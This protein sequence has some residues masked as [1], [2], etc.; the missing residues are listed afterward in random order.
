MNFFSF[1][2]KII[3]FHITDLSDKR[4]NNYILKNIYNFF[5]KISCSYSDYISCPSKK[6]LKKIGYKKKSFF[7]PNSPLKIRKKINT[8]KKNNAIISLVNIDEGTDWDLIYKSLKLVVLNKPN[9][10]L[11]VTGNIKT[12]YS[13]KIL[14]KFNKSN[15]KKNISFVGYL[16]KN[17]LY[18]LYDKCK[19]GLTAYK[20]TKKHTYWHYGDSIKIR[21]YAE[22][23]LIILTEGLYY[24]SFEVK[25]LKLGKIYKNYK[26]LA[27][28]FAYFN[29]FSYTSKD[30]I[31]RSRNW[32]IKNRKEFFLKKFKYKINQD[33]L[34]KI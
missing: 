16:S 34:V 11:Y 21:E 30:Y 7:I 14:Q 27:K 3:I 28:Y 5:F 15:L 10:K 12:A 18:K 4:F 32:A 13:K 1:E 9:F 20:S 2:K 6:I 29:K 31:Q 8:K 23:G 25:K 24:N 19:F 33:F 22:S 26:Q 17:K